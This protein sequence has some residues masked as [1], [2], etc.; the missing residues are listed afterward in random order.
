MSFAVFKAAEIM[1][2]PDEVADR[3]SEALK[4]ALKSLLRR[5]V[6]RLGSRS[7]RTK[8]P[9]VSR[10]LGGGEIIGRRGSGV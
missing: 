2:V 3:L 4:A 10:S 6:L 5:G 7:S 9:S 8:S 1:S